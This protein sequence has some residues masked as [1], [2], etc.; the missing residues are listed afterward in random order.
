M[1]K[2][3]FLLMCGVNFSLSAG[4]LKAIVNDAPI[5]ESEVSDRV[6]LLTAQQPALLQSMNSSE[7]EKMAL[8]N[9]VEE[10]LKIQKSQALGVKVSEDEIDQAINHL[11]QQNGFSVG[12]LAK[13][14]AEQKVP[15]QTLRQQVYG[16]LVWLS[17]ARANVKKVSIPDSAVE[18]RLKQ[19]KSDMAKETF[20]VAEI[21][22]PTLD[23][24]Q[25]VWE[26]IQD[27]ASFSE[28]AR[29]YSNSETAKAGGFVGVISADYF[30]DNITPVMR[31]MPVG[32]VSRPLDVGNAYLILYM[33]DKKASVTEESIELWE[34]AQGGVGDKADAKAILSAKTCDDFTRILAKEGVPQSIQRGWTDP[35]QLPKELKSMLSDVVVGETLGPVKVPQGQLFFMKCGVKTQRVMPTLD[36]VREQLEME[37]MENQAKRLL[38]A[39]KR[40]AV[41]EYK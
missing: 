7:L 26:Q 29:R 19:I 8:D 34:L 21:K 39:E 16:D 18:S 2:I 10:Y 4:N 3:I 33:M 9:L 13:M 27:G 28:M 37:Q 36:E 1:K 17:Y 23:Q 35:F 20:T 30:G 41:I 40:E 12:G 24:A 25:N 31:E 15:M 32:Q 38:N 22:L 11:E 5:F 6:A 14:L